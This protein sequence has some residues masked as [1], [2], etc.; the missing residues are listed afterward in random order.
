MSMRNRNREAGFTLIEIVIAVAI[1]GIFAAVISPMV[2][3][4]LSDAKVSK[5]QSETETIANAIL[6]YYKDVSRW[7]Y[8]NANGPAGNGIDRVITS[9]T[10]PNA[11]GS[12]ADAGARNWGTYGNAKRLGD[13]LYYNNPDDDTGTSGYDQTGQ[14]WPV[15]GRD[16][17]RG[18][19]VDAYDFNDPW[20][21]S[22]VVNTRYCPGGRYT[23][24]VR[25]KVFVLSAGPNGTWETA[26]SDGVTEEIAG[27]D[28]GYV[29]AID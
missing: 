9:N 17:W 12:G 7:P 27:D 11:A 6:S 13:Y 22:Y 18:P 23:G 5:A 8:T 20:G 25:H 19:Y 28:I 26:F 21:N 29:L 10:V 2:Y 24:S 16:S 14:D 3:R 1:I 4:H 15:S